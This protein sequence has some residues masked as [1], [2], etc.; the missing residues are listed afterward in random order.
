VPRAEKKI[1][2]VGDRVERN[3]GQ[4]PGSCVGRDCGVELWGGG[5]GVAAREDVG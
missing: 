5:A 1:E 4:G 3:V 2:G